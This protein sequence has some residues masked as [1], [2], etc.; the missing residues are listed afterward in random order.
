MNPIEKI[1]A[2]DWWTW[3]FSGAGVSI[4]GT[5]IACSVRKKHS[6]EQPESSGPKVIQGDNNTGNVLADRAEN[7]V[8]GDQKNIY[9]PA[10]IPEDKKKLKNIGEIPVPSKV[11]L[12]RDDDL[13]AI[14]ERLFSEKILL[15]VN[16][17]GG[18]GKTTLASHY[19]HKYSAEYKKLIWVSVTSGITDA[20]DSIAQSLMLNIDPLATAGERVDTTI[21][22]LL[23]LDK[24]CLLVMDNAN[25]FDDLENNWSL[26]RKLSGIHIL[27]TTR[28]FDLPDAEIYPV[29]HLNEKTALELFRA[30]CPVSSDEE[31]LLKKILV[32][33][34]YHTLT[35]EIISRSLAEKNRIRRRYTLSELNEDLCG[36]GILQLK[37]SRG[38]K[39]DYYEKAAPEKIIESMYDISDL[40]EEEK[41]LLSVLSVLP[42]Q[43]ILFDHLENILPASDSLEN[44][45]LS[46]S[47]KGWIEYEKIS[48]TD[49]NDDRTAVKISPVVQEIVRKQNKARLVE[50][51][52]GLISGLIDRLDYD[53]STGTLIGSRYIDGVDYA[54]YAEAVCFRLRSVGTGDNLSLL[55]DRIGTFF[56]TY[57]NLEKALKYFEEETDLFEELYEADPKNAGFKNGLAISYEKLGSTHTALGNL[58]K[59]LKY[60]EE[61]S[62]LGEELYEAD[63]KNA[64]FKN[65]L[66]I[67]YSKLGETHTALGN[68]EKALKYFEEETDLFEE[69]YEADPKNAGFKN[70]LAISYYKFGQFFIDHK[71][72]TEAA[73]PFFINAQ[74]MWRDLKESFPAYIEFTRNYDI[75]TEIIS[76]LSNE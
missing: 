12:G 30:Y 64:G 69:L 28:V 67:S 4:I 13:E 56:R 47:R 25:S 61:R 5:A 74:K 32:A 75:V 68:L 38:I 37:M 14:H 72:D 22:E 60:F 49:L 50:D 46:A 15:L 40:S 29:G 62:R 36:N 33:V 11:F 65:G 24:P 48:S 17:I 20:F 41:H 8:M 70:G 31:Q 43:N 44:S 42:P 63:P 3:V 23:I 59:A 57:G 51:T 21:A 52:R 39:T 76:Q 73:L 45:V 66:A 71:K 54:R 18:I 26:L 27:V 2:G 7:I 53:A 35:V 10:P 6:N 58:E 19:Y 55:Y 1:F 34:D 16:G 9:P